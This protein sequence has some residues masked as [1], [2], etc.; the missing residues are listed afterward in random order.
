MESKTIDKFLH[1]LG[2]I[3][4]MAGDLA[5]EMHAYMG[6]AAL[7]LRVNLMRIARDD[8]LASLKKEDIAAKPHQYSPWGIRLKQ[9][10][11]TVND[12]ASPANT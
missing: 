6:E 11:F 8:A 1:K 4:G 12:N 5:D 3:E 9:K 10:T 2:V 7:D